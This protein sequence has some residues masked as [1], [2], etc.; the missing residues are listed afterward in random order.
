MC[1]TVLRYDVL[2]CV[3]LCPPQDEFHLKEQM[4]K[5]TQDIEQGKLIQSM[6]LG[7]NI[8]AAKFKNFI[9]NPLAVSMYNC[10]HWASCPLYAA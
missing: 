3:V 2:R 5:M 4:E 8:H 9:Q 1:C 7:D 6:Q 10:T